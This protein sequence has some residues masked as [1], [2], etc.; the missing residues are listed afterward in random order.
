MNNSCECDVAKNVQI[1]DEIKH[2]IDHEVDVAT[3]SRFFKVIGDETRLKILLVLSKNTICVSQIAE[4]L[5]MTTSAVSHQLRVL[6]KS[7]HVKSEQ[8]GKNVY[9]SLDDNHVV[10]ILKQAMIHTTH[11]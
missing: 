5:N 6:K 3:I 1:V 7:H 9:Y 4:I 2:R 11:Q 8:V 10:E